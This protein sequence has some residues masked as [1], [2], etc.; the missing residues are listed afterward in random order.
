MPTRRVTATRDNAGRLWLFP[1]ELERAAVALLNTTRMTN[2]GRQR[3]AAG[4]PAGP[5]TV[6]MAVNCSPARRRRSRPGAEMDGRDRRNLGCAL[7]FPAAD[8]RRL[9]PS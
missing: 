4:M 8:R 7:M 9:G 2:N 6:S 3:V 1:A 5:I